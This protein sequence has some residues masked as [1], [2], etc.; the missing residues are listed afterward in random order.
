M[1][2]IIQ[3]GCFPHVADILCSLLGF[4]AVWAPLIL[5]CFMVHCVRCTHAVDGSPLLSP[6]NA[7]VSDRRRPFGAPRTEA[8]GD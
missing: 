4:S 8:S 3:R 1:C 7:A 2:V 5:F 6:D